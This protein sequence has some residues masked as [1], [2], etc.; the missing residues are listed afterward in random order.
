MGH[1]ATYCGNG[2]DELDACGSAGMKEKP[3]DKGGD[4]GQPTF[5]NDDFVLWV[6]T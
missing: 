6:D 3:G 4:E 5:S 2:V 1:C